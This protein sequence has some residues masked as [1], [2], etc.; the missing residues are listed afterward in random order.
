MS[1]IH[2]PSGDVFEVQC[3]PVEVT[4]LHRPD[5]SWV[6]ADK[7]GHEH[8]WYVENDGPDGRHISASLYSPQHRYITPTLIWVKDG[9][10][11]WEDDDEPHDVGHLECKQCGEHIQPHYTADSNRQFMPGLRQCFINGEPVSLEE[12]QRRYEAIK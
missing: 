9:E 5:T 7:A 6:H 2:H 1:T 8:R 11:Y 12:F 10:E 3:E 4:S